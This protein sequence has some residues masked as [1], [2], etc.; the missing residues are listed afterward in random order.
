ML[1]CNSKHFSC[2]TLYISMSCGLQSM[3]GFSQSRP[4]QLPR[5]EHFCA[6]CSPRRQQPFMLGI[7]LDMY[8]KFHVVILS[9]LVTSPCIMMWHVAFTETTDLCARNIHMINALL[10]TLSYVHTSLLSAKYG[11]CQCENVLTGA[12]LQPRYVIQCSGPVVLYAKGSMT[13]AH[14]C[15]AHCPLQEICNVVYRTDTHIQ[16]DVH[17]Q[18]DAT[19]Q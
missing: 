8:H 19:A 16:C 10:S 17:T 2:L 4:L 14:T 15:A 9:V 13:S 5:I 6:Q 12:I 7:S 18:C 11:P 3:H 1:H